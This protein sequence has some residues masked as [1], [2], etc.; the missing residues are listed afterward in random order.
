[1]PKHY[2]YEPAPRNGPQDIGRRLELHWARE[3]QSV[4]LGS[5]HW[6]GPGEPVTDQ[7]VFHPEFGDPIQAWDG[8]LIALNRDQINHLITQLR[9]ARDQAYGRD[10]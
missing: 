1:M 9:T 2:L 7:E 8:L 10:Q 3:A 4:V 6:V 5:T